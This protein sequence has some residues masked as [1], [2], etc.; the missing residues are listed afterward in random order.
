MPLPDENQCISLIMEA[1][2]W[3]GEGMEQD[4]VCVTVPLGSHCRNGV[5]GN[6]CGQE[7]ELKQVAMLMQGRLKSARDGF[8]N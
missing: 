2:L 5:R 6:V 1:L 7:L 8:S 4:P 3:M